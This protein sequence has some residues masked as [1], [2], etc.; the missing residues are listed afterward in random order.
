MGHLE[1]KAAVAAAGR[2]SGHTNHILRGPDVGQTPGL[3]GGD[4]M[5]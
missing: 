4:V 5:L 3:N 2:L 1:D